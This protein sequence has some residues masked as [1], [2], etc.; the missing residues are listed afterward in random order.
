MGEGWWCSCIFSVMGR[1]IINHELGSV[2]GEG[3]S[4]LEGVSS[5][6]GE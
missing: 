1:Q 6:V 2:G 4:L 3:E 5:Q